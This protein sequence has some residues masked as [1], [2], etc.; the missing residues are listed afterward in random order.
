MTIPERWI[1]FFGLDGVGYNH[2]C[3][4]SNVLYPPAKALAELRLLEPIQSNVFKILLFL[5]KVS[6]EFRALLLERDDRVLWLFGYWFGLMCRFDGIWW[7]EQRV[8]RD[9]KAVWIWLE[10]L[11]LSGTGVGRAKH[12]PELCSNR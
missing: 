7:C 9:Y 4:S 10:Q 5:G 11:R 12:C 8:K 3:D 2:H 6:A 1:K